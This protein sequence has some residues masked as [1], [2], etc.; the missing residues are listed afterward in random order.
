V[1]GRRLDQIEWLAANVAEQ[2]RHHRTVARVYLSICKSIGKVHNQPTACE[3]FEVSNEQLPQIAVLLL[4]PESG[5]WVGS[6]AVLGNF[7]FALVKG[8]RLLGGAALYHLLHGVKI[9]FRLPA[10]IYYM[11]INPLA[12]TLRR[13][14][15]PKFGGCNHIHDHR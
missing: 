2:L 4:N 11:G 3:G 6:S 15:I 13:E 14:H 10:R 5:D 7:S 12:S 9:G 8:G 1:T